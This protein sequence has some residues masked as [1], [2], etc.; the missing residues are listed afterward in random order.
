MGKRPKAILAAGSDHA[1][2]TR[3][4]DISDRERLK[5]D[6]RDGLIEWKRGSALVQRPLPCFHAAQSV[7]ECACGNNG[8]RPRL[9]SPEP[10]E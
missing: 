4:S 3:A 5:G 2:Q 9:C 8:R 7:S 6:V 1:V 10:S